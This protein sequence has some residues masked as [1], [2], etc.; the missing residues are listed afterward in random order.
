MTVRVQ[1]ETVAHVGGILGDRRVLHLNLD[2]SEMSTDEIAKLHDWLRKKV[3]SATVQ[4]DEKE[5]PL[6][7]RAGA[8]DTAPEKPS[9]MPESRIL[10]I[11]GTTMRECLLSLTEQLESKLGTPN[12]MSMRNVIMVL[13]LIL[14]KP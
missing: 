4:D 6:Y 9:Y 1:T 7:T 14:S 3:E 12:Q 10:T 5:P 2:T 8:L 13:Q 11:Q